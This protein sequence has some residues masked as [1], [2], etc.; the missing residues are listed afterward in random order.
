MLNVWVSTN[1][2]IHLYGYKCCS[3]FLFSGINFSPVRILFAF[4]ASFHVSVALAIAGKCLCL[5]SAVI[6]VLIE[7]L[8]LM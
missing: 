1:L 3:A 7:F 8:R 5:K 2:M 6:R 4:K